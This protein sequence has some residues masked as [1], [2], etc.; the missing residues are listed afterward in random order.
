VSN[1]NS[2]VA[3]TVIDSESRVFSLLLSNS[4]KDP[5]FSLYSYSLEEASSPRMSKPSVA[6]AK[7]VVSNPHM[8]D[9]GVIDPDCW[10][11]V[12]ITDELTGL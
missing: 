8:A 5:S 7:H 3:T 6:N 2:G 9:A 1:V 11:G 12:V 4:K 10:L